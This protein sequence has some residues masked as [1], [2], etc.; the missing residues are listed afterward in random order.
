MERTTDRQTGGGERGGEEEGGRGGGL[1]ASPL[2]VSED[3]EERRKWGGHTPFS[4]EKK[5]VP[6]RSLC[7]CRLLPK[8]GPPSSTV[9]P[10][11]LSIFFP[12]SIAQAERIPDARAGC[13]IKD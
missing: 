9:E 3:A 2:R 4:L 7:C 1:R 12:P 6:F 11:F 13:S 10:S 5:L 8:F